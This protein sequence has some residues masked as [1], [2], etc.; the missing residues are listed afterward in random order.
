MIVREFALPSDGHQGGEVLVDEDEDRGVIKYHLFK[1]V[2]NK[3]ARAL[4]FT[5]F[6]R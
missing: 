5:W 1:R 4:Y 2:L 3:K 6:Q